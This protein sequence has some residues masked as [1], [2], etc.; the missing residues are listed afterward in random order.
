MIEKTEKQR[1]INHVELYFTKWKKC[2]ENQKS[3]KESKEKALEFNER[4]LLQKHFMLI[5]K[6]IKY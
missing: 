5:S 1:N 6:S 2:H 4:K 3:C